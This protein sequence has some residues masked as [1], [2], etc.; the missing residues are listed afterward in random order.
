MWDKIHSIYLAT[1]TQTPGEFGKAHLIPNDT[2]PT[3]TH[4]PFLFSI[5]GPPLSPCKAILLLVLLLLSI[6]LLKPAAQPQARKIQ[7]I[8]CFRNQTSTGFTENGSKHNSGKQL[9][10]D[11]TSKPI[12][13][14]GVIQSGSSI[15]R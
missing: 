7:F 12:Q 4:C 9:T 2:T 1:L 3:W 8:N 5:S 10:I 15:V 14:Y 6:L 13:R 11:S